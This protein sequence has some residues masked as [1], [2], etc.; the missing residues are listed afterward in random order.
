MSHAKK[1]KQW[2]LS[3]SGLKLWQTVT[4]QDLAVNLCD[5][6]VT[7]NKAQFNILMFIFRSMQQ[8]IHCM[9]RLCRVHANTH[10]FTH[11]Q[12]Y[13]SCMTL[14]P[15]VKMTSCI[16]CT[17][18][19]ICIPCNP[20]LILRYPRVRW[21]ITISHLT[22]QATLYFNQRWT[23]WREKIW[24]QTDLTLHDLNMWHERWLGSG[25]RYWGKKQQNVRPFVFKVSIFRTFRDLSLI[26][27]TSHH[28][29][30]TAKT[31]Q[32]RPY[33]TPDCIENQFEVLHSY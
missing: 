3:F 30:N 5:L 21:G 22:I 20:L 28:V 25:D 2:L 26:L 32:Q 33:H 11:T 27:Q 24:T 7:I 10:A 16:T 1:N 23:G 15:F 6:G 12:P 14:L 8:Y 9:V 29:K 4:T 17:A 18:L 31:T 13:F 19:H